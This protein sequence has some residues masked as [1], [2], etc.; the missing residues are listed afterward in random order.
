M[1]RLTV[2]QIMTQI[3]STVNQE[4]SSPTAGGD[5]Y[6]LWL[7]YINRA[8]FEWSNAADWEVLRK[9]YFPTITGSS[10]VTIS[11]PQDFRKVAAEIRVYGN[12]Y[13]N[14]RGLGEVLPDQIGQ[15][16]QSDDYFITRGDI[17]NGFN[18][19]LHLGTFSVASGAS[20]AIEYYSTV[21]SLA[22]PA[23]V[24]VIQDSQFLIDRT[25]AYILEA[26]SDARFQVEETKAREK[27]LAMV[28]NNNAMRFNSYAGNNPVSNITHKS[29]FRVGRD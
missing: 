2:D 3:A 10:N 13:Q 6:L 7:Q 12:G 4:A 1:S 29:G 19:I 23:Q 8:L 22:S 21:T 26:R 24:P 11:M 28:E 18:I 17:N 14:G 16:S 27:L 20:L 5:E 25:I 9:V 15:Y